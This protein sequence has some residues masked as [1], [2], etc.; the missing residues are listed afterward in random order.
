MRYLILGLLFAGCASIMQPNKGR[1]CFS[2][3]DT[4]G[5]AHETCRATEAECREDLDHV[6]HARTYYQTN[7]DCDLR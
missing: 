5:T 1:H 7:S 4:T 3:G 2:W 6:V